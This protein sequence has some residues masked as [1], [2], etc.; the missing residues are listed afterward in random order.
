V[1]VLVTRPTGREGGQ[2]IGVEFTV[3]LP[4]NIAIWG[5]NTPMNDA[6]VW[7]GIPDVM[8]NFRP[9]DYG[10][11]HHVLT[12]I[13]IPTTS[14]PA[15]FFL[16]GIPG[17]AG[18]DLPRYCDTAGFELVDLTPYPGGTANMSFVING[19]IVPD[20]AVSWSDVKALYR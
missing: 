9:V 7:S 15:Q 19:E 8:I 17:P 3:V 16:Q 11:V 1:Y 5:W 10:L 13:V 12:L 4:E 6:I 14:E 18:G 20:E 2:L